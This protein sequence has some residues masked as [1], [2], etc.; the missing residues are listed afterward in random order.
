[1]LAQQPGFRGSRGSLDAKRLSR[2]QRE[3]EAAQI[4]LPPRLRAVDLDHVQP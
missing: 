4:W 2:H 3:R 1:M